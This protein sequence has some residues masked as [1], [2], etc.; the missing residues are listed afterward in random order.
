MDQLLAIV[1]QGETE[2]KS[3]LELLIN[4]EVDMDLEKKYPKVHDFR[5]H[6]RENQKEYER[7]LSDIEEKYPLIGIS[8]KMKDQIIIDNLPPTKSSSFRTETVNLDYHFAQ[9]I[10]D[11]LNRLRM[12]NLCLNDCPSSGVQ[13]DMCHY[14]CMMIALG[15]EDVY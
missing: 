10:L 5:K 4:G 15:E 3:K 2:K 6:L 14:D 1:F 12:F 11:R 7:Q 8:I 9:S 13:R